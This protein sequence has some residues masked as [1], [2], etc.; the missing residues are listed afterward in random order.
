MVPAAGVSIA[1]Q[2]AIQGF[3]GVGRRH[4]RDRVQEFLR[5][6]TAGEGRTASPAQA[7]RR[8]TFLRLRFNAVLSQFDIFSEAMSQRSEA[9]TG[10]WLSGLDVV[11]PRRARPPRL[12]RAAT[13]H[14]LPGA[15]SG[16]RHPPCANAA[17]RWRRQPVAIIRI[18]RERMIGSGIA[19][20][21]VHEVG[22]QG[23]A[24][25]DLVTSLRDG[26]KKQ[27]SPPGTQGV[28]WGLWSRWLSEIVAD[29]GRSPSS[30]W[31]PPPASSAW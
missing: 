19:S 25:L 15:W 27:P 4:L 23:A 30:G 20:S 24:L 10:V 3:L 8:F 17:A 21:L 22:H 9:E 11:C 26:L 2:A 14:V 18:P 16:R 28:A 31:A 13:R 12:P 5:W 7:Q 29:L 6:L 1:A